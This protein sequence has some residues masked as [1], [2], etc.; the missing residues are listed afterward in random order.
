VILFL[1]SFVLSVVVCL[2]VAIL[3]SKHP[4]QGFEDSLLNALQDS[5]FSEEYQTLAIWALAP[6]GKKPN[7]VDINP[8]LKGG[9]IIKRVFDTS[10]VEAT[11][12]HRKQHKRM[13]PKGGSFW[14]SIMPLLGSMIQCSRKMW[15]CKM[16]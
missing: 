8:N 1:G 6:Q 4:L 15:S 16:K 9:L 5:A 2:L 14:K 7:I 10:T 3:E 12:W 11:N 13:R